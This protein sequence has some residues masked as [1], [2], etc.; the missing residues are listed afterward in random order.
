[1]TGII[2]L[3]A[4]AFEEERDR[5]IAAGCEDFVRKPFRHDAILEKIADYLPVQYLY[6]DPVEGAP[7]VESAPNPLDAPVELIQVLQ[8]MPLPWRRQMQTAAMKGADEELMILIGQMPQPPAPF[9]KQLTDWTLN[10]DFDAIIHLIKAAGPL[11][12]AGSPTLVNP[13]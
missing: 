10:F 12:K 8:K 7:E 1:M 13:P 5:V 9:V 4:S 2:A 3:T 11:A 6:E